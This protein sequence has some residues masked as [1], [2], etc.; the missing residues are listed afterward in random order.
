MMPNN[1]EI[2]LPGSAEAAVIEDPEILDGL[3]ILRGTRMPV[4]MVADMRRSG[5]SIEAMLAEYPSLNAELIEFAEV[6]AATH[7]RVSPTAPAWRSQA[8]MGAAFVSRRLQ[9]APQ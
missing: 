3:P 6:Y 8:P 7:R 1:S 2:T 9:T 4:F 5:M